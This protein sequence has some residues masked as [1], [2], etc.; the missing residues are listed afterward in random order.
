[1]QIR[2]IPPGRGDIVSTEIKAGALDALFSRTGELAA[3]AL[4]RMNQ[5][6]PPDPATPNTT[7]VVNQG[8][9][10]FTLGLFCIRSSFFCNHAG[11]KL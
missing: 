9:H 6:A 7:R 1:M 8:F 11:G 3:A 10:L 4:V 5:K 2:S